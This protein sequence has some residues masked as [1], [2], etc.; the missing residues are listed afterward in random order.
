MGAL[1]NLNKRIKKGFLTQTEIPIL[2]MVSQKQELQHQQKEHSEA[3]V[4][5]SVKIAPLKSSANL[6]SKIMDFE[7]ILNDQKTY[8]DYSD[9]VLRSFPYN[10]IIEQIKDLLEEVGMQKLM[11]FFD[12]F[13]EITYLDQRLFVDTILAPL[14][15][16]SNETI[17]IKVAGYPG[18]VYFGK[19]DPGKIDIIDLDFSKLYKSQDVQT[20]EA[21]AIDYTTRLINHR[22]KCF[23]IDINEFLDPA[24]SVDEYMRLFFEATLNVPRL[25]GFIL[26]YSY[27]EKISKNKPITLQS[28]KTSSLKYYEGVLKKYFERMIL[29]IS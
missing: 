23:G 4:S 9:A 29:D 20:A 6:K 17:K 25:L 3:S 26:Y 15:N 27:Q 22:F 12:D 1:N 7:E 13:S 14:N 16:S 19:I 8:T 24:N 10:E 5:G 28:I 2:Q 21:G 18:R 11:L